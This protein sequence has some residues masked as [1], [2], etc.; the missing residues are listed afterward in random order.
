VLKRAHFMTLI[1]AMFCLKMD[2]KYTQTRATFRS[3]RF[4]GV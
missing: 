1:D 2:A 4:S 3:S